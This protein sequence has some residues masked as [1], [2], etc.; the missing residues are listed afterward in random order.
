M[1]TNTNG[2]PDQHRDFPNFRKRALPVSGNTKLVSSKKRGD[3][4]AKTW[5]ILPEVGTFLRQWRE[6]NGEKLPRILERF[7]TFRSEEG[8]KQLVAALPSKKKEVTEQLRALESADAEIQLTGA[9]LIV[10][11]KA[12][13]MSPLMIWPLS[14]TPIQEYVALKFGPSDFQTVGHELSYSFPR[15]RLKGSDISVVHLTLLSGQTSESHRHQGDELLIVLRGRIRA[16]FHD[17]GVETAELTAGELIH[18]HAEAVHTVTNTSKSEPAEVFV[19]RIG[20]CSGG[21]RRRVYDDFEDLVRMLEGN[22]TVQTVRTH[23][24]KTLR[25]WLEGELQE[26]RSDSRLPAYSHLQNAAGLAAMLRFHPKAERFRKEIGLFETG[27]F[28]KT[29]GS[30]TKLNPLAWTLG[31]A[32]KTSL[33]DVVLLGYMFPRVSTCA[34]ISRDNV[35]EIPP[36]S[37]FAN[38]EGVKYWLPMRSLAG[39]EL[40]ICYV[41]LAK[42]KK[43]G[44]DGHEHPGSEIIL[45]LDGRV[46]VTRKGGQKAVVEAG[47]SFVHFDSSSEH[48]VTNIGK[49]SAKILVIRSHR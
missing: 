19:L 39:T 31:L 25:L 29:D 30:R 11:A 34:V 42:G 40:S 47:K 8:A 36:E 38:L 28:P 20:Q 32:K 7:E 5:S 26:T 33:P 45:A 21:V 46:E 22:V 14:A 15:T 27:R 6:L 13:N 41:D 23:W 48:T 17:S 43:T 16:R 37:S 9:A 49:R 2:T 24:A 44:G 18:F 12:Y 3:V 1:P 10:L 35:C 4:G